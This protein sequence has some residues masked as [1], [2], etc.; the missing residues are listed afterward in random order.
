MGM[1][2]IIGFNEKQP[3]GHQ[4]AEFDC[5]STVDF[6]LRSLLKNAIQD[7]YPELYE[8]ITE[9]LFV[10]QIRFDELSSEDFMN[11]VFAVRSEINSNELSEEP[12]DGVKI[13]NAAIEPL[14]I[15][16]ERYDPN[17]K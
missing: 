12:N 15:I 10:E 13:W 6:Y 16:D 11:I 1:L 2:Y 7:T 14:I 5:N 9:E 17:F 3:L 8:K 4:W